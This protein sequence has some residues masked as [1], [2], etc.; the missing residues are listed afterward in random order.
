MTKPRETGVFSLGS[1]MKVKLILV[2]ASSVFVQDVFARATDGKI[3]YTIEKN[4]IVL[5]ANQGFHF[6]EKAPMLFKFYICDDKNTVCEQ[7][8]LKPD[9]KK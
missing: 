4:K 8:E 5:T 1:M 2:L 6:N 7:H 9:L 3:K